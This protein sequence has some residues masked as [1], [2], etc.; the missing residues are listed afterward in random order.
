MSLYEQ[1]PQQ[2][3]MR[4]AYEGSIGQSS[5]VMEPPTRR[6]QLMEHRYKLQS[7]LSKVDAAIAALDE[8]P[9]LE[10]FMNTLQQAGM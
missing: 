6:H 10:V 4:N 5:P 8:H 1:H 9:E 3:L 7:M 2:S